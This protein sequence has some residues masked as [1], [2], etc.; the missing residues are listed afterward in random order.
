MKIGKTLTFNVP[1]KLTE[2]ALSLFIHK[3]RKIREGLVHQIAKDVELAILN[4]IKREG[5]GG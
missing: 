4:F 1:V 2:P 5:I 3:D